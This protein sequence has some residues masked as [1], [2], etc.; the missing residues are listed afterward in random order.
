MKHA[1]NP[2]IYF[3]LIT[4]AFYS[5][6]DSKAMYDSIETGEITLTK[7]MEVD[8]G[9][10][11]M[12][13][14]I[15][16]VEITG[17]GEMLLLDTQQKKIHLFDSAGNF[18]GSELSEGEGPGEVRQV[19]RMDYSNGLA[20][21]YDWSHR[22]LSRYSV[23]SDA[24]NGNVQFSFVEDLLPEYYPNDFHITPDG[25]GYVLI[26]PGPRDE[27]NEI[28]ISAMKEKEELTEDPL[29]SFP[30][31][32]IIEVKNPNGQ[33]LATF[34]SPH[35][36]QIIPVFH[37]NK[38]VL[39][40][41][42]QVGFEIYNL[43]TGELTDSASYN[44]PDID[45]TSVEKRE[46]LED[47]TERM[48]MEGTDIQS[49]ISQMPDQKGKVRNLFYDPDGVMW[50]NL[51]GDDIDANVPEWLLVNDEGDLLGK[52]SEEFDGAVLAVN[53]GKVYVRESTEEGEQF[54]SIYNY[55][56]PQ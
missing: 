10:D 16:Q 40:R 5:C 12:I 39:G 19:G 53:N 25:T 45:L 23:E 6:S 11:L 51:I 47:M 38:L 44:R 20:Q 36:R 14:N 43:M 41:S 27:E 3:F 7:Q 34:S 17:N 30:N 56:L 37:E 15:N 24:D 4:M 35:S 54:L 33:M 46:F 26:Y 32:E 1:R 28:I 18:I 55:E 29:L 13:G 50:L 42:E 22:K 52:V 31:D 49:L 2:L 9:D 48:G 8:G 21:V